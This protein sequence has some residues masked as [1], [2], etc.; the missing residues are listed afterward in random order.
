MIPCGDSEC[1][2]FFI[3]WLWTLTYDLD[4]KLDQ[5]RVKMNH[6]RKYSG[7]NSLNSKVVDRTH[8]QAHSG[9]SATPGPLKAVGKKVGWK[10]WMR[11]VPRVQGVRGVRDLRHDHG[12]RHLQVDLDAQDHR[13]VHGHPAHTELH[14]HGVKSLLDSTLHVTVTATQTNQNTVQRMF[15]Y[16]H[17]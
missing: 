13:R 16:V 4:R 1:I 6:A 14:R 10:S 8:R 3:L 2:I 5:E 12:H 17:T 15:E 7:Q 11:C 9:P